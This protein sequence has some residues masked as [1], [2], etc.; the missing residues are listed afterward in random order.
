MLSYY[1]LSPATLSER[2]SNNLPAASVGE[3][4]EMMKRILQDIS[5]I[6]GCSNGKAERGNGAMGTKYG[7]SR[8]D[9]FMDDVEELLQASR[10]GLSSKG[11]T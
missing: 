2:L 3:S 4:E 10:L 6:L 9:S 1:L 11:K 5:C 7:G 8:L